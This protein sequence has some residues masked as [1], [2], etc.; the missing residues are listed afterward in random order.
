MSISKQEH[1][2]LIRAKCVEL[3]ELAKRRTPGRWEIIGGSSTQGVKA[4]NSMWNRV[5]GCD[6]DVFINEDPP[7]NSPAYRGG[8]WSPRDAAFIASAAGPFEAALTSTVAA[9]DKLDDMPC[10]VADILEDHIIASW[11]LEL[12]Q[13]KNT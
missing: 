2:Q 10:T 1:L 13:S 4:V 11:P 12:L 7:R 8:V 9:I 6:I 5:V 3:L